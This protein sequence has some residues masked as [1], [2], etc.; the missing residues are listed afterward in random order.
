[1]SPD[2]KFRLPLQQYFTAYP[3]WHS[4]FICHFAVLCNFLYW[5]KGTTRDFMWSHYQMF[6]HLLYL[7]PYLQ[8]YVVWACVKFALSRQPFFFAQYDIYCCITHT[9][10]CVPVSHFSRSFILQCKITYPSLTCFPHPTPNLLLLPNLKPTMLPNFHWPPNTSS[11][12]CHMSSVTKSYSLFVAQGNKPTRL[13]RECSLNEK[14]CHRR[15]SIALG[16]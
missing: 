9:L 15:L 4:I 16:F 11:S 1:M 3:S 13:I 5:V 6:L 14:P 7:F 2:Y 8:F 12:P 10:M